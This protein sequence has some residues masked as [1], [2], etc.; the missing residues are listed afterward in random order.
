MKDVQYHT[1][2]QSFLIVTGVCHFIKITTTSLVTATVG[3]EMAKWILNTHQ[4][5]PFSKLREWNRVWFGIRDVKLV[6]YSGHC[7]AQC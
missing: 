2:A 1:V 7:C 3:L 5:N 4:W 6:C